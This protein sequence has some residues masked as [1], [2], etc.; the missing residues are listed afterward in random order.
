MTTPEQLA[1]YEAVTGV[2]NWREGSLTHKLEL[3][4]W[5][6]DVPNVPQKIIEASL[7]VLT[8]HASTRGV[9]TTV[10]NLITNRSLADSTDDLC[11]QIRLAAVESYY[12]KSIRPFNHAWVQ[13]V[14]K[15][16]VFLATGH[17]IDDDAP[18]EDQV[19]Q[20][21]A[22]AHVLSSAS[23]A[24]LRQPALREAEFKIALNEHTDLVSI[25]LAQPDRAEE[26]ATFILER[27]VAD[28]KLVQEF[29]DN[30]S[31][32]LVDGIL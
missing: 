21:V 17:D 22:L 8:K 26:I 19:N 12:E 32:A 20:I 1:F 23:V 11:M 7:P 4:R 29:L 16:H 24:G 10:Q 5:R 15:S 9:I 14:S 27:G 6:N 28:A 31:A 13:W 30:D 25:T 18:D 3:E 2:S